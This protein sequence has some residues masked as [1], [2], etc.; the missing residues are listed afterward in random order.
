VVI[1]IFV[2]PGVV[3]AA[4]GQAHDRFNRSFEYDGLS[5]DYARF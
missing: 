1:G 2:R 3:K 5:G 4:S